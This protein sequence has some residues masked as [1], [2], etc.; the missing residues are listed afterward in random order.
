M[1]KIKIQ[2]NTIVGNIYSKNRT[3]GFKKIIKDNRVLSIFVFF[4][5]KKVH[6][7]PPNWLFLL[8]LADI[9]Q[10]PEKTV[11][12]IMKIILEIES[13]VFFTS[14]KVIKMQIS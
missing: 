9:C 12:F 14:R 4:F 8:F 2:K 6:L 1:K 3:R 5:E 10:F 7:N 13:T 11:D